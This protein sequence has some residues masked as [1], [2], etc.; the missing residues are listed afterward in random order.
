[1]SG[2]VKSRNNQEKNIINVID[3]FEYSTQNDSY[4]EKFRK[5][6]KQKDNPYS[7][8]FIVN[9]KESVF[10]DGKGFVENSSYDSE[11]GAVQRIFFI[12]G[13][14]ML[15]WI[16]IEN[17]FSKIIVFIFDKAGADIHTT[18]VTSSV[19]GNSKAVITAL[20]LTSAVKYAVPSVYLY[21]KLKM[22]SEIVFMK[23]MNSPIQLICSI[24][25]AFA[26]S[27][28]LSIPTA[29][30]DSAKE[31]YSFFKS[32]DTDVS[33]WGQWEYVIYIIYDV[34]VVSVLSELF[35]RGAVFT[36]LRQFGDVSAI[37][38]T[39]LMAGLL[40]QNVKE[41]ISITVISVIASLGM[42]KSGSVFTAIAVNI[43]CKMYQLSIAIIELD[44]SEYMFMVRNFTI[45]GVFSIGVGIVTI[46]TFREID[47]PK[48]YL[49]GYNGET[50]LKQRISYV[51]HAFPFPVVSAVCIISALMKITY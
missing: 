16:V 5:W 4:N 20:I 39:S 1:M 29:Y 27:A 26:V 8:N 22:P 46:I 18:L 41:F 19:Y 38:I 36:A 23:T 51:I 44:T 30:S 50:P 25:M 32:V 7:F 34:I 49:A 33:V 42:L 43:L 9:R 2:A 45:M 12:I 31:I 11:R 48:K 10:I 21:K 13:I 35:F 3:E 37:V 40:A 47:S 6:R 14:A 17:V 28:V 24:G 15:L